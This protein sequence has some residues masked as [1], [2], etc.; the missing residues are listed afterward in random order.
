MGLGPRRYWDKAVDGDDTDWDNYL[1]KN[2]LS[3]DKIVN[4]E[5]CDLPAEEDLQ[6]N[7]A[8]NEGFSRTDLEGEEKDRTIAADLGVTPEEYGAAIA[9]VSDWASC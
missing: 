1:W 8:F 4:P 5:G 7:Q 3:I 6:V 9:R 2:R